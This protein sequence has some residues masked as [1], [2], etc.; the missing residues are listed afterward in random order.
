M[1]MQADVQDV[2]I[3]TEGLTR[4]YGKKRGIVDVSLRV[5]AGEIF[6]YLGPN[7]AGKTT[8]IRILMDFIRAD[9]GRARLFG[10]DS[11]KGSRDIH[12]RLGYLPGELM[13]YDNLTVQEYLDYFGRLRGGIDR[14]IVEDLARRLECDLTRPIRALSHGNKQKVGLIQALM[15][16]PE[17]LI[18]DEPTNG[19][20]PLMRQVFYQLV[21]EIKGQGRTV[22]L[23][24]HVLPEVEKVCDRVAIIRSG[25]IA[26]V[27]RVADLRQRSLRRVEIRFAGSTPVTAEAFGPVANVRDV[28]VE[29]NVLKC[30]VSGE[31]DRLI[32]RAAQFKVRSLTSQRPG[33]EEIFLEYYGKAGHAE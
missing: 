14:H 15:H 7:G 12:R 4:F 30:R 18:L 16:Q 29:D 26:A 5:F 28:S 13:L 10:L 19:L 17:L 24:S 20:D 23:S 32:K 6:G 25:R 22:F 21:A 33:L 2:V 11:R 9:R 31:M 8:T 3:H 27:E 1:T